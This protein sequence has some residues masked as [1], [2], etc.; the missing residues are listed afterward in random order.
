ML[1]TSVNRPK[2]VRYL[3]LRNICVRP[4]KGDKPKLEKQLVTF[5]A[6]LYNS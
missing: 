3:M 6:L 5:V 1:N 4:K 2:A